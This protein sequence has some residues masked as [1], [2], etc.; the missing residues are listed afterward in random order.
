MTRAGPIVGP[1]REKLAVN[2]REQLEQARLRAR[3][4]RVVKLA[5]Q[6]RYLASSRTYEP[7]SYFE[8]WVSPWGHVRCTCPSFT[9]R[10]LRKH[11]SPTQR[12]HLDRWPPAKSPIIAE[13]EAPRFLGLAGSAGSEMPAPS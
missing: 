3:G 11:A 9:Y 13:D 1:S 5:G 10:G 4:V 12:S 8:L 7:G 6:D 2:W